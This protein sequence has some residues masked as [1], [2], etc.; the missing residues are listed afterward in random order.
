MDPTRRAVLAGVGAAA[1]GGLA[2]CA[3]SGAAGDSAG[4]T[5]DGTARLAYVRL[6]NR[7]STDHVVHVLVQRGGEPVHWSSHDLDASGSASAGEDATTVERTWADDPGDFSVFVRLDDAAEWTEFDVG[8][9]SVACYGL[10]TRIGTDGAVESLF[11]KN[12][13]G[14]DGS[15]ATD[16]V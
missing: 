14:C 6:V 15:T 9:G 10:E 11:A 1:T 16:A 12:P 5:E 7:H 2:G 4:P 13:T 8:D 3:G